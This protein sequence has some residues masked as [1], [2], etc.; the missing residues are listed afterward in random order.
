VALKR[1]TGALY[2]TEEAHLFRFDQYVRTHAAQPPLG[3]D[4]MHA[5]LASLAHLSARG[6][7]NVLGVV[8]PA[9]EYARCHGA[10]V[11]ELPARPARVPCWTRTRAARILSNDEIR[12]LL[13]AAR[14]LPARCGRQPSTYATLFGLLAVTGM[15][16]GEALALDVQDLD[17]AG[18]VVF[19]RHGK[20]A[21]ARDVALRPSTVEEL[22]RHLHA[23]VRTIGRGPDL[24]VFVSSQRR[25]LGYAGAARAFHQA[26]L[27]AHLEPL[28]RP[29]DLRHTFAVQRVL[30]WYAAGDDV[31]AWLP[32][33]ST[34]LGHASVE[35]TRLYLRQNGLLL[36]QAAL[37][38]EGFA[39]GYE[40]AVTP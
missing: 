39:H 14:T 11:A 19:I 5:F 3:R 35:N 22:R 29:H 12:S 20:F 4:A 2:H 10:A 28:P 30:A 6:R 7:D 26:C 8:W 37:R 32:A 31:N 23:P 13:A 33:L 38:F 15:R 24:P 17:L 40:S 21:K 9:L 34:Y 16:I 1:A 18:Q 36:E 25:R 27:A